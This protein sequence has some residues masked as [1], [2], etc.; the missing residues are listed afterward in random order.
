MNADAVLDAFLAIRELPEAERAAALGSLAPAVRDEVADLLRFDG[1]APF[2]RTPAP[3]APAGAP[4]AFVGATLDG[5]YAVQ[6][7]VAEGGFG[8]VFR[9]RDLERGDAVAV[10]LFKPQ[11][12]DAAAVH[13]AIRREQRVL[14]NLAADIEHI[15][16]ARGVGQ[17]TGPA[18]R[19]HAYLVMDWLDGPTLAE[20]VARTAADGMSLGEAMALLEPVARALGEAHRR[21]VAHRD[22]KPANIICAG[23][24]RRP[25]V[26]DFG[27]AKVAA[28][29]AGGFDSTGGAPAMVTFAY[30]APEQLDRSL[31]STGP[32]SD[33]HALALIVV[34]LM[35]GRRAWGAADPLAM[36][37]AVTDP[38]RRPT[39]RTLGSRVSDAVEGVFRDALAVRPDRRPPDSTALWSRLWAA[40]TGRSRR[41][42]PFGRR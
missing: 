14:S 7:W 33:V 42:W 22:L 40:R 35:A 24:E 10:K 25:V 9:G 18:A 37:A 15:V 4:P 34:E 8:W 12:A 27:A 11:G 2:L 5:R 39:P 20:H 38:Q 17:W 3:A 21:G 23:P 29:R 36:M 30:S 28:E 41:R 26:V 19:T 1:D 6:A 16:E 13:A 32:W 31:G